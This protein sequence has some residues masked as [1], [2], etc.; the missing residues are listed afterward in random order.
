MAIAIPDISTGAGAKGA[1][2]IIAAA[3]AAVIAR[4]RTQ[5]LA[6]Y[7]NAG[8]GCYRLTQDTLDKFDAAFFEPIIHKY[9]MPSRNDNKRYR[10]YKQSTAKP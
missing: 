6:G 3:I 5:E 2:G 4:T 8:S 10:R 9:C 7:G 1:A